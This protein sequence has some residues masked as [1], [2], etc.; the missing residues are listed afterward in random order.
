MR[1][2]PRLAYERLPARSLR[3]AR[4]QR[5]LSH[6]TVGRPMAESCRLPTAPMAPTRSMRAR[7]CT[8]DTDGDV[9]AWTGGQVHQGAAGDLVDL[10]LQRNAQFE[11]AHILCDLTY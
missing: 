7:S 4:L 1:Q 9:G 11:H 5:P 2:L 3:S 6:L 10:R 8:S